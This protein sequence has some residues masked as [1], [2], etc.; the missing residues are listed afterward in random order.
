MSFI[1]IARH[2]IMAALIVWLQSPLKCPRAKPIIL[3]V[4]FV[5]MFIVAPYLEHHDARRCGSRLGGS[6]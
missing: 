3:Y 4:L 6:A 1:I 5:I 2:V